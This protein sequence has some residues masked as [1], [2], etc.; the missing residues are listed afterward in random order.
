MRYL[1]FGSGAVGSYLGIR[2]ALAGQSVSFLTRDRYIKD[3][4]KQGYTIS[5]DG[6]PQSLGQPVVYSDPEQA[7]RTEKPDF[8]LLTVK[9]YDVAKA[10][11]SLAAQLSHS[12]TVVSFLNG[13]NNESVLAEQ[14]GEDSILPATLTS[15]VQTSQ[16]GVVRVERVR[17]IGLGGDHP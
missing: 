8:I 2:L 14:L 12:Q 11:R 3:I 15:A 9:A 1:I 13:I 10:A 5:G 17:G 4:R 16:P 7:L 6:P